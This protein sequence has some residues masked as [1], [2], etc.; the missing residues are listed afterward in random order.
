[1]QTVKYETSKVRSLKSM[2]NKKYD[3]VKVWSTKYDIAKV[4]SRK[5]IIH[6]KYKNQQKKIKEGRKQ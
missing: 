3:T 6:K 2:V 1:M 4:R 5:S